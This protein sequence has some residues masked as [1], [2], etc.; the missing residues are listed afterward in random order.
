MLHPYKLSQWPCKNVTKLLSVVLKNWLYCVFC[1]FCCLDGE[2]PADRASEFESHRSAWRCS[3]WVC[4]LVWIYVNFR[5][6]AFVKICYLPF[7]CVCVNMCYVRIRA[8]VRICLLLCVRACVCVNMRLLPYAWMCVF[9]ECVCMCVGVL[10]YVSCCLIIS[11]CFRYV[12]SC[13]A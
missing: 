13:V 6:R 10:G 5:L 1:C 11:T 4:A 3:W 9:I 8:R 12:I 2:R 7:A